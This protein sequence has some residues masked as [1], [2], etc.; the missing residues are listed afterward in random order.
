MDRTGI[1]LVG[2]TN[3][4]SNRLFF[5]DDTSSVLLG[6]IAAAYS[7][8]SG[9]LYVGSEGTLSISSINDTYIIANSQKVG[10][11]TLFPDA[12]SYLSVG[13]SVNVSSGSV[14]RVNGTQVVQARITGWGAPT[15]TATRASF[16]TSTV[17]LANLAERVKAL[18]DDLI[19]HGLIGS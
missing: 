12:N 14:Y 11:G 10:I 13:G 18:I 4:G 9:T 19:T 2:N 5:Y 16:I 1:Q 17:T 7:A 3:T 6:A 15:G 8:P